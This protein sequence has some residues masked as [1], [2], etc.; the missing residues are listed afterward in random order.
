MD[1]LLARLGVQAV[2]YALRSGIA[3]TSTYAVQQ[4]SR[5][6]KTVDDK[7]LHAELKELQKL[8]NSKIK[9]AMTRSIMPIVAVPADHS[10]IIS[11]AIDLIEFKYGFP[12]Y[13]LLF[14]GRS[15][16]TNTR[17]LGPAE[18]MSS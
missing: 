1:T 13:S 10:Q 5:L 17:N 2:N 3:I 6:L 11:P 4:C 16:F 9:V 7:G 18:A 8:L 14:P 12:N 15:K